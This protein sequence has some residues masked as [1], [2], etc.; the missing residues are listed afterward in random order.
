MA[1]AQIGRTAGHRAAAR[2]GARKL[3]TRHAPVLLPPELA[4]GFWGHFTGAISGGA[5][6][7]KATFLLDRLGEDVFSPAV[8]LRQAPHLQRASGSAPHDSAG[9]ATQARPLVDHGRL[10]RWLL[11]SRSEERRVGTEWCNTC[12]SRGSPYL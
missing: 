2:L 12:R 6:Y 11:S 7:R 9:V 5:L 3:D 10:E 8:T 4:R 1:P